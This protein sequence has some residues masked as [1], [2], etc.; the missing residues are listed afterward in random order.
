MHGQA[1]SDVSRANVMKQAASLQDL[2]LGTLL[3]GIKLNTGPDGY[4]AVEQIQLARF[5]GERWALFGEILDAS[6]N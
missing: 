6:E 1:R 4:F 5:D 2:S 3:P